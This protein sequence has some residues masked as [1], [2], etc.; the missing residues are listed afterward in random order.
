MD[1]ERIAKRIGVTPESVEAVVQLA[2][3]DNLDDLSEDM[4]I[5]W[6]LCEMHYELPKKEEENMIIGWTYFFQ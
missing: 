1:I 3:K 5:G 2:Q 4:I 6:I